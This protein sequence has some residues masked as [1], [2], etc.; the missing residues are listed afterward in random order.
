MNTSHEADPEGPLEAIDTTE[1]PTPERK[2]NESCSKMIA[3]KMSTNYPHARERPSAYNPL[4]FIAA[5]VTRLG[6]KVDDAE[7][8]DRYIMS[9]LGELDDRFD[10]LKSELNKNMDTIR[11]LEDEVNRL[12]R[13]SNETEGVR[14]GRRFQEPRK[15]ARRA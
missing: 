3:E 10:E 6:H 9:H 15:R 7:K 11:R 14:A 5:L 12:K 2:D 1:R 8:R 13:G 4:L